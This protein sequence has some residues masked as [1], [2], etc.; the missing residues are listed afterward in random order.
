MT[1]FALLITLL[2]LGVIIGNL[3]LLKH[4]AKFSMKNFNQDPI[5]R[6]RQS[7]EEKKESKVQNID[8]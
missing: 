5:E 1:S 4:S 2:V 7:L 3:M 6:A 8:R